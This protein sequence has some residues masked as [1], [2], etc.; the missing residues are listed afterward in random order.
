MEN[1]DESKRGKGRPR[2][3]EYIEVE[4]LTTDEPI[5]RITKDKYHSQYYQNHKE[6][7]VKCPVCDKLVQKYTIGKHQRT[8]YC[9]LVKQVLEKGNVHIQNEII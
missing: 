3:Y 5:V 2:R 6:I 7:K 8:K 9:Q 1:T 4:Q